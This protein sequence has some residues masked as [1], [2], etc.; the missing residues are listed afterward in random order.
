MFLLWRDLAP[1]KKKRGCG[2]V[3]FALSD[4]L[5][6]GWEYVCLHF[7]PW[8]SCHSFSSASLLLLLLLLSLLLLLLLASISWELSWRV[9]WV[10]R[11]VLVM[12]SAWC[13]WHDKRSALHCSMILYVVMQSLQTMCYPILEGPSP[14]DKFHYWLSSYC[15]KGFWRPNYHATGI[16]LIFVSEYRAQ[17]KNV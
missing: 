11:R 7:L 2:R 3:R 16:Q 8:I 1:L 13:G 4:L 5:P 9:T 14:R 6:L 12:S 17:V 10:S 15:Y